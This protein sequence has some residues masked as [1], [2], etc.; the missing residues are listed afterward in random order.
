MVVANRLHDPISFQH[1]SNDLQSAC[2]RF[3]STEM[4]FLK[5]HNYIVCNMDN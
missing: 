1:L 3:H 5:M 2:K 4:A